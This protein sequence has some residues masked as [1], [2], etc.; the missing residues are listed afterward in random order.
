MVICALVDGRPVVVVDG[1]AV[2]VH[3]LIDGWAVV[4]L[5]QTTTAPPSTG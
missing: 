3:A 1:G 4:V 2:V 5:A